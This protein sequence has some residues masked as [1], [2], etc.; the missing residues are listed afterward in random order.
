MKLLTDIESDRSEKQ[1]ET[2]AGLRESQG[3][4]KQEL[5]NNFKTNH[6]GN[7]CMHSI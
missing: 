4:H 7:A 6:H 5:I 1:A 2:W 3:A